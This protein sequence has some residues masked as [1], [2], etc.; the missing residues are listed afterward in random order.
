MKK[1]VIPIIAVSVWAALI[2]ARRI[3]KAQKEK[4]DR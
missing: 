4:I 3:E 2:I 1:I